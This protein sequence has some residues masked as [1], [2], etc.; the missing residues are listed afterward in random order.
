[1]PYYDTIPDLYKEEAKRHRP[2]LHDLIQRDRITRIR[3]VQ[4]ADWIGLLEHQA[5]L[6]HLEKVLACGLTISAAG[7]GLSRML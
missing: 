4:I 5:P 3:S 1:M 6:D 2:L 7:G